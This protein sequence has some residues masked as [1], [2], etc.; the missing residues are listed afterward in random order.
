MVTCRSVNNS[1]AVGEAN[2]KEWLDHVY[3][4]MRVVQKLHLRVCKRF[5]LNEASSG[6]ST[7]PSLET[8]AIALVT[9]NLT[10]CV[11]C[12]KEMYADV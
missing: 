8:N 2:E 1:H 6:S 4:V 5:V 12:G 3:T 10:C 11:S 7:L 9:M